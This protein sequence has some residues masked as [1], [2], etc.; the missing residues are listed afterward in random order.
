MPGSM[1][2]PSGWLS[3]FLTSF[4]AAA[5][6]AGFTRLAAPIWSSAP[7]APW[8]QLSAD[9]VAADRSAAVHASVLRDVTSVLRIVVP[10][11]FLIAF[12]VD[13]DQVR[14]GDLY[15]EPPLTYRG[16]QT[17]PDE[18]DDDAAAGIW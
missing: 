13:C 11:L 10:F 6:L 16:I 5:V 3:P 12:I 7:H 17:C 8:V 18:V 15:P 2:M 9:A 4:A 14:T 1:T